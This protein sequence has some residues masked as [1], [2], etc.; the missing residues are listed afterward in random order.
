M[1]E[2]DRS[3]FFF[4]RAAD[5][6]EFLNRYA[7]ITLTCSGSDF[8]LFALGNLKTARGRFTGTTSKGVI[9]PPGLPQP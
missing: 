6:T 2:A 9:P 7:E 3:D 5:Q 1:F 8:L 4:P